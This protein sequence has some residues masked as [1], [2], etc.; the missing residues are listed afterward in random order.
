VRSAASDSSIP[1]V[2]SCCS[3]ITPCSRP[4]ITPSELTFL[5]L[6]P[7]KLTSDGEVCV[8]PAPSDPPDETPLELNS[9]PRLLCMWLSSR[10]FGSGSRR[11]LHLPRL[12][13]PMN[14]Y[15]GGYP[16]QTRPLETRRRQIGWALSHFLH[17][18]HCLSRTCRELNSIAHSYLLSTRH[19]RWTSCVL[20]SII[21]L[22]EYLACPY[23][24]QALR[25]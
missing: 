9:T 13:T 1:M 12:A 16:P 7:R 3:I 14:L 4:C 6:E 18:A 2:T 10:D 21:Y 25:S 20:V 22:A 17:C 8:Y 24:E 15:F 23:R 5:G 11:L 19:A